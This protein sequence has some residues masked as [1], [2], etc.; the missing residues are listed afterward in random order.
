MIAMI[1]GAGILTAPYILGTLINIITF[2][3]SIELYESFGWTYASGV[4]VL[5][6]LSVFLIASYWLGSWTM[7]VFGL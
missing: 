7:C 2:G 1:I 4:F 5:I 3:S 6:I